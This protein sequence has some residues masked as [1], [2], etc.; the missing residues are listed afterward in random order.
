MRISD[1]SSDVCSSDL[2]PEYHRRRRPDSKADDSGRKPA[3]RRLVGNGPF[4]WAARMMSR[5]ST[6]ALVFA[7][8]IALAPCQEGSS[9]TS[10]PPPNPTPTPTPPP[11]GATFNVHPSLP[12]MVRP[13]D[14]KRAGQG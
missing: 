1:W 9:F 4:R 8:A 6:L 13:G 10:A 7:G 14:R 5:P 2:Q 11:T 3:D 12:Q